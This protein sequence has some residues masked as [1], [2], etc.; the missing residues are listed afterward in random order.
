MA[1]TDSFVL[2]TESKAVSDF[3]FQLGISMEAG[4]RHG[5]EQ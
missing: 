4:F 1:A 3:F 2:F 5:I